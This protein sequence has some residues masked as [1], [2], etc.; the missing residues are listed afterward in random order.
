MESLQS[1]RPSP[2]PDS[3]ADGL[4]SIGFSDTNELK[5]KA[6]TPEGQVAQP[7]APRSSRLNRA[8]SGELELELRGQVMERWSRTVAAAYQDA[9]EALVLNG[10][11][12][13]SDLPHLKRIARRLAKSFIA[14]QPTP[15]M[16]GLVRLMHRFGFNLV[17]A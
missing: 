15:D 10:G 8:K 5:N 3:V 12:P 16:K 6:E 9:A 7:Q 14:Y 13:A 4:I 11:A 2:R 1:E 17:S